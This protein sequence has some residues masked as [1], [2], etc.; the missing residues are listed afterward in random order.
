M[1]AAAA[2]VEADLGADVVEERAGKM[3][4]GS[5]NRSKR[6]VCW[7]WALAHRW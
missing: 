1:V 5:V 6:S 2:W 4:V 7:G 3:G